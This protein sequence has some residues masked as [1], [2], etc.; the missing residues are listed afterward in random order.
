[1][2]VAFNDPWE[3]TISRSVWINRTIWLVDDASAPIYTIQ[4]YK[5]LTRPTAVIYTCF[6][7][8]ME[9]EN[10]IFKTTT[11]KGNPAIIYKGYLYWKQRILMTKSEEFW[12]CNV[13]S[14]KASLKTDV[15][16]SRVLTM[17]SEHNHS[18]SE[19]IFERREIWRQVKA[20]AV[21]SLNEPLSTVV[22]QVLQTS[23]D[24]NLTPA[25]L[26][27]LKQ[28]AY[29]SRCKLLASIPKSKQVPLW[30]KPKNGP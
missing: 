12:R 17:I 16:S 11:R 10:V 22:R 13:R 4:N 9:K 1:M 3:R 30:R 6:S 15:N 5:L 20:L 8:K 21:S 7:I 29:R 24:E 18:S 27:S 26:K 25:D 23:R 28:A 19:R 2:T 14:C